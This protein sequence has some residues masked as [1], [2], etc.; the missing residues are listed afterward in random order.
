VKPLL[1]VPL[2]TVLLALPLG[3]EDYSRFCE[4]PGEGEFLRPGSYEGTWE[5]RYAAVLPMGPRQTLTATGTFRLKIGT[6][7]QSELT[8][9]MERSTRMQANMPGAR[10][11]QRLQGSGTLSLDGQPFGNIFM[12][13]A[14]H[15]A[16]GEIRAVHPM[17]TSVQKQS[18]SGTD[19]ME[20]TATSGDC[21]GASGTVKVSTLEEVLNSM[22]A[23]GASVT[24]EAERWEMKRME[25]VSDQLQRF[26]QELEQSAP[27]G[28][29]WT[30]EAE[31]Q[32]WYKLL[33]TAMQREPEDLH[34][35]LHDLWLERVGS[36]HAEWVAEDTAK[37]N[38]WTGAGDWPTLQDHVTRAIGT[39][40]GL[41]LLGLDTCLA[42]SHR[43]LWEAINTALSKHL[44]RMAE[45]QA[46]L[47][48]ILAVA[49]RAE[50]LGAV[51]PALRDQYTAAV[52]AQAI[53]FADAAWSEYQTALKAAKGDRMDP[54]VKP[55]LYRAIQTERIANL[56]GAE[57]SRVVR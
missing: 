30:R 7:G 4:R 19:R 12:V 34:A 33:D 23:G 42:D 5:V 28:I 31:A 10:A 21:N 18:D 1:F 45:G 40:R 54:S 17:H 3:A 20:F 48:D 35:C 46:P 37:L 27:A 39:S 44:Q 36:V 2:L 13:E 16:S 51:S 14:R 47:V 56:L 38:A 26:K 53:Q 57:L 9:T 11:T 50:L 15:S 43:R 25:D 52:L 22:R 24:A 55:S 6:Q 8:G 29:H 32:R 41:C 49:R